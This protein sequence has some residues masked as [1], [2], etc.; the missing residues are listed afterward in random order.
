MKRRGFFSCLAAL[1]TTAVLPE[2]PALAV[3]FVVLP[4]VLKL[5]S[6]SRYYVGADLRADT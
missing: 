1:A 5:Y 6:L 3:P 4:M 2:A